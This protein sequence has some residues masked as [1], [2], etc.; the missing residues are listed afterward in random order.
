MNIRAYM[1]VLLLVG[2]CAGTPDRFYTLH[3]APGPNAPGAATRAAAA[4]T[5]DVSTIIQLTVTVPS[6]VD[7][8]EMVLNTTQSRV[9]VLDHERWAAPFA[10]Q[11]T[12][13][14]AADLESRRPGMI[15]AGRGFDRLNGAQVRIKVDLTGVAAT[16]GGNA[17]ITVHWR[18]S[19]ARASLDV[20][21]TGVFDAPLGRDYSDVADALSSCLAKLAD[22]LA[23]SLPDG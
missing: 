22:R 15:V 5:Q 6:M 13:V 9:V 7:R 14:L 18:I 12:A 10:D 16:Q 1:T 8:S 2:G 20:V 4:G 23:K 3:A 19:D 17:R 11:V 21:D